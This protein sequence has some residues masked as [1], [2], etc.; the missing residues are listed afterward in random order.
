M[1]TI[2]SPNTFNKSIPESIKLLR[3]I[4]CISCSFLRCSF[5][6]RNALVPIKPLERIS[7]AAKFLVLSGLRDIVNIRVKNH[8]RHLC[9]LST[10]GV[11]RSAPEFV[12]V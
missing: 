3:K 12:T 11:I 7:G 9:A 4:S 1:D 8:L 2:L 10:G 5:L 6:R